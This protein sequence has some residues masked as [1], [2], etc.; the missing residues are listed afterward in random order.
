MKKL[1]LNLIFLMSCVLLCA[2][3]HEKI[4]SVNKIRGEYTL[5]SAIDISIKQAEQMARDDAKRQAL[6]QVCGERINSWDMMETSAIG[7]SF[8]SLN[9]IQ[10]DGEIVEFDIVEEGYTPN[11]VKKDEILFYCVANVKVKK[12]LDPDPDFVANITGIKPSYIAGSS[13]EFTII[14]RQDC[15]LK[16]FIFED[17]SL[18]YRLYPSTYEKPKL[19]TKEVP[20]KFPIGH[21]IY[22]DLYTDKDIETNRLVF[23]FTKKEY[24]FYEQTTSREEIEHWIASIPNDQKYLYYVSINIVQK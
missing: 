11:P 22:Y 3:E 23:V 17:A 5:S 1:G 7:E 2:I 24:P 19:L 21:G 15:Y 14:P 13:L 4:I 8:N 16:V 6:R 20:C 12:G 10:V 9:L 18:G